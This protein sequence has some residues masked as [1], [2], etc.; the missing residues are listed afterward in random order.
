M[1]SRHRRGRKGTRDD[2]GSVTRTPDGAWRL[3]YQGP[4]GKRRSGGRFATRRE[5]EEARARLRVSV[6]GGTW[7]AP[8]VTESPRLSDYV[9]GWLQRAEIGE[10]LSPRT[11]FL[12]R[13]AF[14]RLVLP[15]VGGVELGRVPVG[16]LSRE[17][18]T[19]WELAARARS[20]ASAAGHAAGMTGAAAARRRGHPARA[21]AR[22]VGM[23][24]PRTG[25][26]PAAVVRAWQEAGS[27]AA[28]VAAAGRGTGDRQFEQARMALSAVCTDLVEDGYLVEH[29]VRLRP[30]TRARRR[31]SAPSRPSPVVSVEVLL[32]VVEALPE[33]YGLAALVTAVAGLRGGETFALAVRH[34]RYA[35]PGVVSHLRVERALVDLPGQPVV[36]GPPKT[37]AGVRE[38]A[39]PEQVGR[40]LAEHVATL[41]NGQDT[42]LTNGP[43]SG[44]DGVLDR[45][46][47]TTARGEPVRCHNRSHAIT[48]ARAKVPGAE[49]LT[50]HGLRHTGLT[51]AASV[52][53]ATVR[54]IM[55]RGGHST[56]RA[57]LIY[58]HT[59]N[60]ADE[61]IAAGLAAMLAAATRAD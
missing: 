35:T 24:V 7:R 3:R 11:V 12:Y 17:V 50:W 23:A 21:W 19:A 26:L 45:L 52:P 29:P 9:E 2:W 28:P 49:H 40:L 55:D 16:R 31:R 41:N 54:N 39:I 10:R 60:S 61:H 6:M 32:R 33:P 56:P 20:R 14:T 38:V 46:L 34:V 43:A 15:D 22:S 36:F 30:G 25:R 58:Q 1:A 18:V 51:L 37:G 42:G 13:R 8:S 44:Q 53:G 4:D 27:P 47:F 57:A 5:A 48:L 59:A